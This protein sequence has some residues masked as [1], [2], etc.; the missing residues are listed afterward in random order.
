MNSPLT[1][2][3][4]DAFEPLLADGRL[5]VLTPGWLCLGRRIG[6]HGRAATLRLFEDNSLLAAAVKTPGEGRVLVVDAGGSLRCAVLGGNLAAAAALNGW[7]GLI[8][9]GC[10]RDADE[11]DACEIG[12][13]ALALNPR[14]SVKRG[15]GEADVSV[16]LAGAVVA[17]GDWIYADRDGVLVAR[18]ALHEVG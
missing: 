17:P 13:R 4:C 18:H 16:S 5:Q 8:I 12:V 11:I 1:T 10:A 15:V 3:L 14:R 6:F 9:H 2:D 7:A